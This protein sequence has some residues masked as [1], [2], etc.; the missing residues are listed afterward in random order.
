MKNRLK[1]YFKLGIFLFGITFVLINCEN[2]QEISIKKEIGKIKFKTVE[3]SN[4]IDVFKKYEKKKR[5]H[6]LSRESDNDLVLT[7][8]WESTT[9]DTLS[10]TDALLTNAE[11]LVNRDGNYKSKLFFIEANDSIITGINTIYTDTENEF[12]NM[13]NGRIYFNDFEGN[14]LAA[15]KVTDGVLSHRLVPVEPV[16]EAGV[17]SFLFLQSNE[18]SDCWNTDNLPEDGILDTVVL[19]TVYAD[20]AGGGESI[21]VGTATYN[22]DA[23]QDY[24]NST[25]PYVN[26]GSNGSGSNITCTGGKVLNTSTNECECPDGK[27]EDSSGNCIEECTGGKILDANDNCVCPE[28]K[29]ENERGE[30]VDKTPCDYISDQ[31]NNDLA[32][33]AKFDLLKTKTNLHQE[34]GYSEIEG[35]F[36]PIPLINGGHSLDISTGPNDNIKGFMHTHVDNFLGGD[37]NS[38]GILDSIKPIRMFSPNDIKN[39]L[40]ISYYS[41]NPNNS[42]TQEEAYGAMVSS[43]GD[44]ML[45]FTGNL[46]DISNNT[47]LLGL[48]KK[49]MNKLKKKYEDKVGKQNIAKRE[50]NFFRFIKKRIG[51]NGIRLY[52]LNTDGTIVEKKLNNTNDLVSEPCQ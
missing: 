37:M 6:S 22:N 8:I 4:A 13:K 52:K 32:F 28:G 38:D 27:V 26:N 10:F 15:Y 35:T 31:I 12:G 34:T 21:G 46:N 1:N 41:S 20:D 3:V 14:F 19:P 11:V 9:Q 23:Y 40:L 24:L 36:N 29:K 7:P 42:Y 49:Q 47:T 25:T 45:K 50:R 5:N 17:L 39:L 16:Q 33:K 2:E 18:T 30:C 51:I 48:T 43:D 44:Y